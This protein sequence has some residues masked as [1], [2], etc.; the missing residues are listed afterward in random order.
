ML[1]PF[2]FLITLLGNTALIEEYHGPF[3]KYLKTIIHSTNL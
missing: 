2:L 3:N 1:P